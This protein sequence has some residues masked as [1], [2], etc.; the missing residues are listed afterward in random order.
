MTEAE[1]VVD[2]AI[3]DRLDSAPCVVLLARVGSEL[4]SWLRLLY[5]DPSLFIIRGT[6][7]ALLAIEP[8]GSS[9][10]R[11]FVPATLISLRPA[12]I[13]V[14]PAVLENVC[15][16]GQPRSGQARLE[17]TYRIVVLHGG[18]ESQVG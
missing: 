14:R 3:P 16:V 12:G 13:R 11:E 15:C 5:L 7:D 18:E 6:A 2:G 17:R 10:E 4:V 9:P 1:R 8:G